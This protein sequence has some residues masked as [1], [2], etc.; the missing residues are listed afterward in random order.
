MRMISL[1]KCLLLILFICPHSFFAQDYLKNQF[2]YAKNLFVNENYFDAITEF[3]RLKFFDASGSFSSVSDEYIARCYKEGAW[4]NEAIRYFTLAEINS[5]NS[6][7]IFRL[8]IE[9]IRL[10]ILRRTT[11]NA[12]RLLNELEKDERWT[13]RKDEICYWRGWAFI[14]SDDWENGAAEFSKISPDHELKILCNETEEKRYSVAFAKT[15]SVILPGAG[16][17]Y[18]GNFLS[19]LISLGWN[20]LWGYIAVD[21]FIENRIFDGLAV[22]NFLWFRF[23]RGNIQNAEKFA[24]EKN[25]Q[26]ANES[27][28]YL[29]KV[30]SGP[31]P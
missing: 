13:D 31:K 7:D 3:K 12:F 22:A 30:Y 2:E 14:F 18:T 27:L 6:G 26:I 1:N 16:Q 29:Q 10:N 21:S 25:I 5:Q 24:I 17:F 19:G 11:G 15:A 9:I 20:A 23:Y 28:K 4:F 8:K